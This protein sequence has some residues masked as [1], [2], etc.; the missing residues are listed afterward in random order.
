M[1]PGQ[2]SGQDK[3][4]YIMLYHDIMKCPAYRAMTVRHGYAPTLLNYIWLRYNGNNNGNIA[5]SVREVMALFECS[6]KLAVELLRMLQDFG[7]IV[8]IQRGSFSQKTSSG[9]S[10]ATTWRL[11]TLPCDGQPATQ[12]YLAWGAA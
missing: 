9:A 10:R 12:D 3:R 7:F 1:K 4:H 8:A 2:N 6:P 11:T 5:F